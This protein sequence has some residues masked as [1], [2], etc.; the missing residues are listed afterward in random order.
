MV[1][2]FGQ[3]TRR[4]P[5]Y[6]GIV[7]EAVCGLRGKSIIPAMVHCPSRAAHYDHQPYHGW[8]F[9]YD[10]TTLN[11]KATY[12]VTPNGQG[13]GAGIW[14]SGAAPGVDDAGNLYV[15]TGNGDFTADIGGNA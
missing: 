11:T 14:M 2:A 7:C 9:A 10:A 15:T 5:F 6:F 8:I 12:C 13:Y 4:K 3:F 1:R